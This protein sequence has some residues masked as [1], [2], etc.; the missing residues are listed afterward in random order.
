LEVETFATKCPSH[1][2]PEHDV[3]VIPGVRL[4]EGIAARLSGG[5]TLLVKK[6]LSKYIKQIHVEYDSIVVVKMSSELFTSDSPVI[7]IGVY[8]PPS[9]S[10][11]YRDTD[12]TN[13][14]QSRNNV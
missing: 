7:L 8:L 12:I 1:L 3:F 4:S 10:N 6:E 14:L 13:G 9:S 5:L 11:Y 2:F